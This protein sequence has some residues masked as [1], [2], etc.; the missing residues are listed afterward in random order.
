MHLNVLVLTIMIAR[1]FEMIFPTLET[2]PIVRAI[3]DTLSLKNGS[4]N[5]PPASQRIGARHPTFYGD[6][7]H[8][9]RAP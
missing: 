7:L 9:T 1:N 5:V 8:S 4:S 6:P 3:P 2:L